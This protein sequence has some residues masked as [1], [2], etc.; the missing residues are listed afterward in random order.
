MQDASVSS[1]APRRFSFDKAATWAIVLAVA[2]A[3][4]VML[5]PF[6]PILTIPFLFTKVTVLALGVLIA[7]ALFILARLTRG[8]IVLPPPLLLGALWFV[9][10]A[11][12]LSTL[13]SGVSLWRRSP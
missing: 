7:L 5:F 13:F 2:A 3:A 12:A 1:A 8:N 9:P 11:Y 4:L 6:K 10:L